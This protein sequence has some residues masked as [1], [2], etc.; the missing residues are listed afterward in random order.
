MNPN[1]N[2][3]A[4]P[5]FRSMETTHKSMNILRCKVVIAGEQCVGKSAITQM[6]HS[7]GHSYPKNY[8][9]TIG[10]DFCVKMVNIPETN[11]A[12]ELYLFDTAGQSIFNQRELGAKYVSEAYYW[13][14][15]HVFC[16]WAVRK[17]FYGRNRL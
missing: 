13:S 2:P 15:A 3:D 9:M 4:S 5:V 16:P 14:A 12:V 10:V 17:C 1:S 7:G 8:V 11:S 6:F